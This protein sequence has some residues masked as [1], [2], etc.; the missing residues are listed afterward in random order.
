MALSIPPSA[1]ILTSS[2]SEIQISH[3]GISSLKSK[4]RQLPRPPTVADD[5]SKG[6]VLV[7]HPLPK[8]SFQSTLGKK[9][10]ETSKSLSELNK[11]DKSDKNDT[12][13]LPIGTVKPVSK[14]EPYLDQDEKNQSNIRPQSEAPKLEMVIRNASPL[15]WPGSEAEVK[16][17]KAEVVKLRGELDVQVKVNS[18]LKKLLVASVGDDLHS[19]VE[20]LARDRA[21]L[22]QELGFT[23]KKRSED[24]ENLD[25]IS[26]QADMWRSKYLA[27]RVMSDEL[28]S[29]KSF[30][31][32]QYQESQNAVQ[33][34]LDERH[35]LRSNMVE[36]NRS[37]QQIRAAFDP[38]NIH[39]SVPQNSNNNLDLAKANHNLSESIKY[40][41]LPSNRTPEISIN[42]D[43][44][45]EDTLTHAESY[46]Y[47][48]LSR[49]ITTDDIK[50]HHPAITCNP[51]SAVIP[52]YHPKAKFDNLTFN[53]CPHCAG[54]IIAV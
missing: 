22:T 44:R 17:L 14:V 15:D 21:E 49:R 12:T 40:R 37:L 33:Q 25:A 48:I 45:W 53:C 30:F 39:R 51:E 10:A 31:A 36:C 24:Y 46:A 43:L 18:E 4:G 11:V 3:D 50:S 13:S 8:Y 20:R 6:T 1:K 32:M 16:R 38:L 2:K 28:A 26:I 41:L 52:R 19:R 34:L 47:E 35:E 5:L 29:A 27:S 7:R 54:E 23:T 9:K 42:M